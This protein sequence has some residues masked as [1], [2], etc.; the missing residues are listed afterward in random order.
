MYQSKL[1]P[2]LVIVLGFCV[3][4]YEF[5]KQLSIADMCL[6]SIAFIAILRGSYNYI[7]LDNSITL[8]KVNNINEGFINKR[9]KNKS[10][11]IHS[12]NDD[13][14][15]DDDD[16]KY[17]I[18]VKSEDSEE[19]LDIENDNA[20]LYNKNNI[21]QNLKYTNENSNLINKDAVNTI[22]SLLGIGIHNKQMFESFDNTLNMQVTEEPKT[23]DKEEIKS[24]FMPKIIIGKNKKNNNDDDDEEDDMRKT[25][26]WNSVF[27]GNEFNG[28]N[29][30]GNNS[31]CNNCGGCGSCGSCGSCGNDN[32]EGNYGND[33]NTNSNSCNGS[34]GEVG[35]G[36]SYNKLNREKTETDSDKTK[37]GKNNDRE[38]GNIVVKNYTGAKAWYPGYTYLPPSNWDVPQKRSPACIAPSPDTIKL[39]GLV[40]RGLPLN[41]LELNPY[42]GKVAT[43][44]DSVNLT[45]VGSMMP[46]FKY[47]ELPFSKPYI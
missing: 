25:S 37:C 40:D 17:D 23:E 8:N 27:K 19:Y 15:D 45:N 16:N 3:F 35:N 4:Y 41:V 32:G 9:N 42:N 22:D 39:T 11:R 36:N 13:D 2:L 24:I 38:D 5:N 14:D 20:R 6:L 10:K 7:Q 43:T 34:Y 30:S 44:E 21:I 46:K 1:L 31:G 47:E 29:N 18:I 12:N 33:S 28:S 26:K